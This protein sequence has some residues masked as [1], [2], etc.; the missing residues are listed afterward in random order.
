MSETKFI[1]G[2]SGN[3]WYKWDN[4]WI[5]NSPEGWEAAENVIRFH[6]IIIK[7]IVAFLCFGLGTPVWGAIIGAMILACIIFKRLAGIIDIIFI[8]GG[9]VLICLWASS[10]EEE[11]EKKQK[12]KTTHYEQVKHTPSVLSETRN[13]ICDSSLF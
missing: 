12:K 11:Y 6:M 3:E 8:I 13:F 10:N 1:C 2:G 5:N 4:M 9:I 7:G